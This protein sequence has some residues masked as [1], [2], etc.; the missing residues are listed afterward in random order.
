MMLHGKVAIVIEGSRG[1]GCAA[2]LLLANRGA[3]L[4]VHDPSQI[5]SAEKVAT[6]IRSAGG[7]AIAYQ[8]DLREAD[9]AA[10]LAAAAKQAFGR[11][12]ILVGGAEP[13]VE[14]AP[15]TDQSWASFADAF[16]GELR[17]AFVMTQAVIPYM[18]EQKFG[19]IIYVSSTHGKDPSPC[20]IA[21]GTAKG[22]LN[23]FSTYIAQE[24]GP[25][26]I[27]ANVVAHG[28]VDTV[29]A[30]LLTEQEKA[31]ISSFTP[32]GRVAKPEDVASVI[33]FLASDDAR[34]LTGTYTPVTGGLSME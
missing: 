34:F 22:A 27:T 20:M 16:Q 29:E 15:F 31:M 28:F 26:G 14:A 25:S 30:S 5:D 3:K 7:E 4:V 8:A 11:I 6:A 17:P 19:R 12:D 9:Q 2:S 10:M 33:A 24:F 1:I 13:S 32:L 18:T 21:Q 23:T